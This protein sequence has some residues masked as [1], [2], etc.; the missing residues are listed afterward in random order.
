MDESITR[1]AGARH[2]QEMT[3]AQ[4]EAVIDLLG[5]TPRQRNTLYEAV[6]QERYQASF[7]AAQ[8]L[9]G[10]AGAPIEHGAAPAI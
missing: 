9:R 6:P 1:A 5:C 10:G 3:P 2:G 8:R 4:M 7:A